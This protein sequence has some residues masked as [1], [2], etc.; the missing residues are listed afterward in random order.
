MSGKKKAAPKSS[1]EA[2]SCK[3]DTRSPEDTKMRVTSQFPGIEALDA[4]PVDGDAVGQEPTVEE[5][6]AGAVMA[7]GFNIF[8]E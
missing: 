3:K 8:G 5:G 1:D 7:S 2:P 4:C 6:E